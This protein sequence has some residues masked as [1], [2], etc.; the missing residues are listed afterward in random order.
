VS[1]LTL[2]AEPFLSGYDRSVGTTRLSE[3]AD[4]AI[5]SIAAPLGGADALAAALAQAFGAAWPA[6]GRTV[7][8]PEGLRLLGLANDQAFALLPRRAGL[9]APAI[10]AA[11]DGAAYCTEQTDGWVALRLSGPLALAALERTCMLDLDPDRFPP[12]AIARTLMEHLGVILLREGP[13]AFLLLSASSSARS[14]LHV[15]E[16]SIANV[17]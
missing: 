3:V 12:G 2:T 11:L 5:V 16:T 13:D 17:R 10:A 14:F 4:L 1:D 7:E 15:L 9:A 6:P 8:A